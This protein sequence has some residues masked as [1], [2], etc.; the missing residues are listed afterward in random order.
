M[1]LPSPYLV[2]T[3]LDG[4]LLDHKSYSFAAAQEA[5]HE[6][7]RRKIPLVLVTSKTRA[8]V[9]V[10]RR[11]LRHQHPFITENGG[12]VFIPQGYFP[13]KIPG[14][15]RIA[16]YHVLMLARPYA[17]MVE[18]LR[19][20]AAECGAQVVGFHDMSARE[21]A[22]NTGLSTQEAELARKRDFD[23]PF[24]FAGGDARV[25]A[26]FARLAKA[27]GI[28]VARGGRFWHLFAGS[29]KGKATK[30]LLDL[31]RAGSH[32]RLRAVGLGDSANDIPMLQAVDVPYLIPKPDGSYDEE[33]LARMPNV[34]RA[35][36]P[37]PRGWNEA[38]LELLG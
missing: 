26:E 23:E 18:A 37:G 3:D 35:P 10:L 22:R 1:A 7:E 27:R 28:E 4:T 11:K 33:V 12:G 13:R 19:E 32:L 15:A 31:F 20:L 14:E 9:E 24:F 6:L 30:K 5:L 38:V 25:E 34:H 36:A 2:F 17:E 8:E 16:R 29:D 21:V